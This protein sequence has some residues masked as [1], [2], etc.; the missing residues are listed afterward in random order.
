M[1]VSANSADRSLWSR[2]VNA[3]DPGHSRNRAAT[4]R[5]RSRFRF[6]RSVLILVAALATASGQQLEDRSTQHQS[7]PGVH[8][9]I[10][11][12]VNGSI[13]VT[14][15][16]GGTVEM[17]VEKT[18]R[19]SSQDRLALAKKEI[20]LNV[21]REGGLLRLMVD[22]PF[23]HNGGDLGYQFNYDF[24]LRVPREIRRRQTRGPGAQ[25]LSRDEV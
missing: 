18:L 16:S 22:G 9:L 3:A 25:P 5:E 7:F 15:G 13:E 23:R 10:L 2:L 11:D 19:A 8:D 14:G 21:T 6:F 20:S 12:N 1:K 4:V 24:K 17:D